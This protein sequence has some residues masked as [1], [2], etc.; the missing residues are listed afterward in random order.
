M[1]LLRAFSV[2]LIVDENIIIKLAWFSL[3]ISSWFIFF[4]KGSF[5]F[6]PLHNKWFAERESNTRPSD[7]LVK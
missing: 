1:P 4:I 6:R 2:I 3:E 5:N 7:V